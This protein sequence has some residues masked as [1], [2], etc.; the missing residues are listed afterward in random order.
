MLDCWNLSFGQS[1]IWL[2]RSSIGT[3]SP[4]MQVNSESL[5]EV[6]S[7]SWL[8]LVSFLWGVG[9]CCSSH[10]QLKSLSK[11]N[12]CFPNIKEAWGAWRRVGGVVTS[13]VAETGGG[14]GE[15]CP[16]EL[17]TEVS[18]QPVSAGL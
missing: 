16:M 14:R 2:H 17:R 15:A 8:K 12:V 11:R 3:H 1:I 7:R 18:S 6:N 10:L 4:S 9:L 5:Q 13:V